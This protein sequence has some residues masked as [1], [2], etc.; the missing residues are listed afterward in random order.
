MMILENDPTCQYW[1]EIERYKRAMKYYEKV[2]VIF[3]RRKG[4][5]DVC[6]KMSAIIAVFPCWGGKPHVDGMGVSYWEG[7]NALGPYPIVATK[8]D[9]MASCT[10]YYNLMRY[11]KKDL[12]LNL[13]I[14][15]RA[16]SLAERQAWVAK[17]YS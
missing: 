8:L 13:A 15:E 3:R 5:H 12:G 4:I 14:W 10:E 1:D 2:M 6:E 7:L 11:L 17:G 9:K 16:P